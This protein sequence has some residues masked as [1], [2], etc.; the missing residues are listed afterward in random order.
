M[1]IRVQFNHLIQGCLSNPKV[2]YD[3][4]LGHDLDPEAYSGDWRIGKLLLLKT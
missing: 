3:M 4:L 2:K 1:S